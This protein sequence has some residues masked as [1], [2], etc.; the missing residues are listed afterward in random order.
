MN[1]KDLINEYKLLISNN[2]KQQ[3]FEEMLSLIDNMHHNDIETIAK[4]TIESDELRSKVSRA[5][6]LIEDA[7][8]EAK[9]SHKAAI[10]DARKKLQIVRDRLFAIVS[11]TKSLE[12]QINGQ[13]ERNVMIDTLNN[14]VASV[15]I[16]SN[17]LVAAGLWDIN[18]DLPIKKEYGEVTKDDIQH[19]FK[20]KDM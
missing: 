2:E 18:E 3:F 12:V 17:E 14:I 20:D 6:A 5:S 13:G 19:D 1:K 16:I 9:R 7:Q 8:S 10:S 4:L 11:T 15:D